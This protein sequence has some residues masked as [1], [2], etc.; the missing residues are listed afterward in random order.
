MGDNIS[1]V[2]TAQVHINGC[3]RVTEVGIVFESQ[4]MRR[5]SFPYN[6]TLHGIKR[7]I[8]RRIRA[9]SSQSVTSLSYRWINA[10]NHV[11]EFY[12]EVRLYD[13]E[14]VSEMVTGIR[15]RHNDFIEI[16]AIVEDA[17]DANAP[18]NYQSEQLML[19]SSAYNFGSDQQSQP[20]PLAIEPYYPDYSAGDNLTQHQ[21]ILSEPYHCPQYMLNDFPTQQSTYQSYSYNPQAAGMEQICEMMINRSFHPS[22]EV[23]E[24]ATRGGGNSEGNRYCYGGSSSSQ[25]PSSSNRYVTEDNTNFPHPLDPF[26]ED[27][28]DEASDSDYEAPID[29]DEGDES[30]LDEWLIDS[31]A[32][33]ED[34][35]EAEAAGDVDG[36]PMSD[37]NIWHP[38]EFFTDIG[39]DVNLESGIPDLNL[40]ARVPYGNVLAVGMEWREKKPAMC[41]IKEWSIENNVEFKVCRSRRAH[42]SCRCVFYNKDCQWQ[43]VLVKKSSRGLWTV[44]SIS[45]E[46][47][48]RRARMTRYHRNLDSELISYCIKSQVAKDPTIPVPN[49]ICTVRSKYKY[50]VRYKTVWRAKQKALKEAYGEFDGSYNDLTIWIQAMRDHVPGSIFILE[51]KEAGRDGDGKETRIFNRVFWTFSQCRMAF[52]HCKPFIQIDGTFLYGKYK[53]KLLIAVGQDGNKK[54]VPLAFA[55]CKSESTEDWGWFIRNLRQHVAPDI[56]GLGLIS[57]RAAGI[58]AAVKI[59]ENGWAEPDGYHMYCLRHIASNWNTEFGNKK[60]KKKCTA[61]VRFHNFTSVNYLNKISYNYICKILNQYY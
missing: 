25:V 52:K 26:P 47:K 41:F 33:S 9:D 54:I 34:E 50:D 21:V 37:V 6:V 60:W 35:E 12:Y 36:R 17:R 4:I 18:V 11:G 19:P 14:D 59:P 55:I 40:P 53:E 49:L 3:T 29:S 61:L 24:T 16:M 56:P 5:I 8:L 20:S 15:R 31:D 38:P 13:D 1:E 7:K 58:I 23:P 57:D 45:E 28:F 48:C 22:T 32:D 39:D 44:K 30:D 10:N 51:D 27:E 42:V 43:L 46:H 2:F